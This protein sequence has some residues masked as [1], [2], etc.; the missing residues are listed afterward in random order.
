MMN[1]RRFFWQCVGVAVFTIGVGVVGRAFA[2]TIP[3]QLP[4]NVTYSGGAYSV[5]GSAA[6]SAVAAGVTATVAGQTVT[7]PVSWKLGQ[8][9]GIAVRTAVRANAIGLGVQVVADWV[10]P[11]GIKKCT[12]YGWCVDSSP[13]QAPNGKPYPNNGYYMTSGNPATASATKDASCLAF[14]DILMKAFTDVIYTFTAVVPSGGAGACNYTRK[15]RSDGVQVSDVQYNLTL[16]N[17]CQSGHTLNNGMCYPPGYVPPGSPV[18]ATDADWAKVPTT[19]IPDS[20][21]TSVM[22]EGK[23]F[24]PADPQVSTQV[25]TV[26]MSSVYKDPTTGTSYRDMA[27]V[28]PNPNDPQ[29]ANLQVV[30]TQVDP[31]T[32]NPVTDPTTG[33]PKGETKNDPCADNPNRIG[34]MDKGDIPQA[35]DLLKS[36]K[37]I[38]ITP[39]SGWGPDTMACP[40]DIVVGLRSAGAMPAVF[41]FKPVCDGADMFRPV[42]IGLAWLAA[43]LIALGMGRR[44]D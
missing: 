36:E 7:I 20:V 22:V 10:L 12:Q 17:G 23:Q 5:S 31:A 2:G 25:Q 4:A 16:S 44:G 37:T 30:K 15:R 35:P 3:T 11:Y 43:V 19:N 40:A 32:G 26:P 9:A 38:T 34:C 14:A 33:N 13:E 21:L 39:D 42:V 28:T 6:G 41:S 8:L 24:F 27:Y 1:W 29:T 18:Q